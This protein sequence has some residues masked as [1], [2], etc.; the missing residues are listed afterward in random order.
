MKD[1]EKKGIDTQI[2]HG[3]NVIDP[4]TGSLTT[5]LY[6]TST[7]VF[8]NAEE[9]ADK[10][11]NK[12]QPGAYIYTRVGSPTQE[13]I[14]DKIA[15]LEGG[16]AA[17]ALSSGVAA[18]TTTILTLCSKGDHI[19]AANSIYGSTY[20]FLSH[21]CKR[22]GIETTFVDAT[23]PDNIRKAMTKDT[24]I[25][26]IESPSNPVLALVDIE[27]AANI[28]HEYNALL[29]IDSTFAS[30]YSQNPIRI[31]AD[32]VIHSATKYINGHGDVIAGIIVG[33]KD[34]LH[35][36]RF[37]GIMDTTG[38]CLSPFDCWLLIRGMKTLG[39]RMRRVTATALEVAE[40]LEKHPRIEAVYYP[41]LESHP[42]HQ[43]AKK[44]MKDFGAIVS[45]EVKGG[46]E[47]GSQLMNNVELCTLAVSLGDPETLIEHPASM[48]HKQVPKDERLKA[49]ITDGLVRLSIGFE[50][51]EDIMADLDNA[52]RKIV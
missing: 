1:I 33:K 24:K 30:P 18:I 5:A 9:A 28:A 46:V 40:F 38:A 52:L 16:E 14:E 13:Q 36:V 4:V 15:L 21:H 3:G 10:F 25:V 43:L 6:Q 7:F 49:G 2:V 37:E 34:I 39:I 23:D 41:G 29:L 26:Y 42:Q 22:F 44:Q 8:K 51:A 47:A 19:V 35:K 31:G 20:A 27:A 50:D 11:A 32:I 48:T 12:G 45:F 17:L